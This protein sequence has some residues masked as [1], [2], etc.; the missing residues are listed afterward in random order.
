[1]R[2]YDDRDYFRIYTGGSPLLNAKPNENLKRFN[3]NVPDDLKTFYKIHNGFG[4]VAT[5]IDNLLL[6]NEY[7]EVMA[8]QMNPVCKKHNI[9]PKGYSFDELLEFFPNGCGNAQCFY[10]NN[11]N[12][13]VDWDHDDWELLEEIG[14]FE[15]IDEKMSK[16]DEE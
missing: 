10:K 12:S 2:L 4:E 7:I 8:E 13:T 15:F 3:W 11:G 14:F 9:K 6:A 5:I 1:M 16:I